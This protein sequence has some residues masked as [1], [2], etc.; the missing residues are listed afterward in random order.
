V[1]VPVPVQVDES[2]LEEEFDPDK[3]EQQMQ[4]AFGDDYYGQEDAEWTAEGPP[5][6]DEEDGGR[7]AGGTYEPCTAS[8]S[9]RSAGSN[10]GNGLCRGRRG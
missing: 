3:W 7:G 5:L 2:A 4:Q 1:V 6:G 8:H 10:H 9:L